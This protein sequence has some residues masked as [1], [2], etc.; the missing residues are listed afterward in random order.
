MKRIDPTATIRPTPEANGYLKVLKNNGA[1]SRMVDAYIFA[2]AYA[3]KNNLDIFPIPSA[4]RQDLINIGIVEDDVRLGL[5]A[6]VHAICKR[7]NRPEPTDSREVLEILSQYAEAGLKIL[8]QRWDG[9]VGIQIQDDVR[10]II[11]S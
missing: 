5:E 11:G 1:F 8:K 10:K 9:K 6:G 4:G 2:A 7:N 3:I